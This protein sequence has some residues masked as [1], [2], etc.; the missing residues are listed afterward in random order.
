MSILFDLL[1]FTV[2]FIIP[3]V[4]LLYVLTGVPYDGYYCPSSIIVFPIG[5]ASCVLMYNPPHYVS[6]AYAITAFITLS[7]MNIGPLKSS[8]YF[9]PK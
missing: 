3:Y 7:K 6:A 4:V 1:G 5:T 9:L 8:P 2:L